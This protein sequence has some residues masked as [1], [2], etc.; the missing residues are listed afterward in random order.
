MIDEDCRTKIKGD[1]EV[2]FL[3]ISSIAM[4][5]VCVMLV[6]IVFTFKLIKIIGREAPEGCAKMLIKQTAGAVGLGHGV[7][8]KMK[9]GEGDDAM[10]EEDACVLLNPTQSLLPEQCNPNTKKQLSLT[11]DWCLLVRLSATSTHAGW[12][13]CRMYEHLVQSSLPLC[14]LMQQIW[15]HRKTNSALR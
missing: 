4:L 9:K 7:D 8:A 5:C 11:C 10:M 1:V 15:K 2:N 3:T 13:F 14:V 12:I 6:A